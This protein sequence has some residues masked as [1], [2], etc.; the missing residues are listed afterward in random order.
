MELAESRSYLLVNT[1]HRH[2]GNSFTKRRFGTD[3]VPALDFGDVDLAVFSP[4]DGS[5][6][7]SSSNAADGITQFESKSSL[8]A[9]CATAS[10]T[11]LKRLPRLFFNATNAFI[12]DLGESLGGGLEMM[13]G[14]PPKLSRALNVV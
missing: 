9:A 14:S 3:G 2:V 5:L 1:I 7:G 8:T 6:R 12:I 10:A 4:E 13:T 11:M